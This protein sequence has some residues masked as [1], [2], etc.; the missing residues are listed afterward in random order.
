MFSDSENYINAISNNIQIR[1]SLYKYYPIIKNPLDFINQ[2][3]TLN[4]IMMKFG[5]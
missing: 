2:K 1:I 5:C 4:T 3:N